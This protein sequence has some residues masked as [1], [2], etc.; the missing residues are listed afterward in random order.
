MGSGERQELSTNPTP[1]WLLAGGIVL[2]AL[3]VGGAGGFIAGHRSGKANS[4]RE[5]VE[6]KEHGQDAIERARAIQD[7]LDMLVRDHARVIERADV[8]ARDREA[9]LVAARVEAADRDARLAAARVEA[10]DARNRAKAAE[11]RAVAAARRVKPL[12]PRPDVTDDLPP[13]KWEVGSV[14]LIPLKKG[15]SHSVIRVLAPGEVVVVPV[16]QGAY[17]TGQVDYFN[18]GDPFYVS[19]VRTVGLMAQSVIRLDGKFKVTGEK[20]LRGG[21]YGVFDGSSVWAVQLQK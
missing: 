1:G 20:V 17:A 15:Q 4:G 9:K 3:A 18:D 8:T 2:V 14:G 12:E 13:L 19:G 16:K 5:L 11:E 21:A 7:K 10:A 6:A